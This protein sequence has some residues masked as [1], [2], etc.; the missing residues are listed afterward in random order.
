M[1]GLDSTVRH[2]STFEF[3]ECFWGEH[4]LGSKED[5]QSIGLA[6]AL[7]FPGEIGGPKRLLHATDLRG[8]PVVI[9]QW[10][11]NGKFCASI[12]LP[13]RTW[14]DTEEWTEF[15]PGVMKD[16]SLYWADRYVG[17]EDS[18]VAAGLV[19]PAHFPGKA[20]MLKTTV[21]VGSDDQIPDVAKHANFEMHPGCKTVKRKGKYRFEVTVRICEEE[22]S[23]RK[24]AMRLSEQEFEARMWALPRP[25]NLL[26]LAAQSRPRSRDHLRLVWSK[27]S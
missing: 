9:K 11:D 23:L 12:Y 8:F 2:S 21:R 27:P 10:D 3:H 5:L 19:N 4:Y 15:A 17:T 18:L 26:R 22:A 24:K 13:G 25:P 1:A 14:P 7:A 20:G 6:C 16:S